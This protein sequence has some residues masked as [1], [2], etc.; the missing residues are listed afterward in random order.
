[1]CAKWIDQNEILS[2]LFEI[3]NGV[4]VVKGQKTELAGFFGYSFDSLIAEKIQF[5]ESFHQ[6]DKLT[7]IRKA[8]FHSPSIKAFD[9]KNFL[10]AVNKYITE[11]YRQNVKVVCIFQISEKPAIQQSI[12]KY[13]NCLIN[14]KVQNSKILPII[15]RCKDS[16][17]HAEGYGFVKIFSSGHTVASAVDAA[18]REL[19]IVRGLWNILLNPRHRFSSPDR[20]MNRFFLGK[21]ILVHDLDEDKVGSFYFQG[22]FNPKAPNSSA[23]PSN[24]EGAFRQYYNA[25]RRSRFRVELE[26]IIISYCNALDHHD[27]N[28][29]LS[30]CWSV[31][32]QIYSSDRNTHEKIVKLASSFYSDYEITRIILNEIRKRRNTIVHRG[33]AFEDIEVLAWYC[34]DFCREVIK[35]LI[36]NKL[37]FDSL[38]EFREFARLS[39]DREKLESEKALLEK[40]LSWLS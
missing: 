2:P 34:Q 8:V 7:A 36:A 30:A 1:M 20:P 38:L 21:H 39:T 24:F 6:N 27:Y 13:S 5:P 9:Q 37:R 4:R 29:S 10:A 22:R 33:R 18:E 26:N 19:N 35:Y 17:E 25:L 3:L 14:T 11:I 12:F 16:F 28:H 40:R 15:S 23:T 32:E 31:L